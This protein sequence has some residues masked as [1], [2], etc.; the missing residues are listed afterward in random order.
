MSIGYAALDTNK[1]TRH[2]RVFAGHS[3]GNSGYLI[4]PSL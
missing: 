2:A 3:K 4:F 1:K